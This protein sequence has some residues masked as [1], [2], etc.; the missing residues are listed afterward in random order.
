M[1]CTFR[2]E[3]RNGGDRDRETEKPEH[4]QGSETARSTLEESK[5]E[6]NAGH[7]LPTIPA[8]HMTVGE[9]KR[10]Q[11]AMERGGCFD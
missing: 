2:E 10:L 9:R 3:N 7:L 4:N 6:A 1:I 8:K 5:R 11:W